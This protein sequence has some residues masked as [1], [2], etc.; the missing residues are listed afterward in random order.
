[1][2]EVC[3]GSASEALAAW[4]GGARRVEL[5]SALELGGLTPSVAS[6]RMVREATGLEVV[7][8]ARPRGGGFCYG[9]SEWQQLLAEASTLLEEGADGI[10]FGALD[11]SRGLDEARVAQMVSLVHAH[12][13][14]AVFHRAFDLVDDPL[15][16]AR[17]LVGLGVDRLLTSGQAATAWEGRELIRELRDQ[18]G[19]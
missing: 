13:A 6:L 2:I 14:T 1:M 12:G 18:L 3:C 15:V 4:R 7:A 10:A 16:V 9:D 17:R 5:N 19:D 11:D 8:M